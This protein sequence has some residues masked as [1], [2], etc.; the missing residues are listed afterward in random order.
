[1]LV[2]QENRTEGFTSL[3][4]AETT[5]GGVQVEDAEFE[6]H[7]SIRMTIAPTLTDKK[8][9]FHLSEV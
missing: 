7:I 5:L 9:D 3:F 2:T 1:M 4:D 8:V 6:K